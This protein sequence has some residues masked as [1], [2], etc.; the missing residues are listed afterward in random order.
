MLSTV[1]DHPDHLALADAEQPAGH[2]RT[3][4]VVL[5][6]GTASPS[7]R[8]APASIDRRAALTCCRRARRRPAAPAGAPGR[9]PAGR[10][11]GHVGRQ[12]VVAR[13]ASN[14]PRPPGP[15]PLR[16]RAPRSRPPPGVWP[17]WRP[18]PPAHLGV[19]RRRPRP[20]AGG[21][22]RC[23][24]PD[25]GVRDRISLP[26]CSSAGSAIADVVA[27]RLA[28]LLHAVGAHQQRNGQHRLGCLAAG[29]AAA[30]GRPG[31]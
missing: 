8:T 4:D 12:L 30:P 16:G 20:G 21:T 5:P 22:Q 27:Q 3:V 1:G 18:R 10:E 28:H 19:Q 24:E 11:L 13:T 6:G 17:R 31:C 14:R 9:Q 26:N 7:S 25:H 15:R 2:R 23:V 29:R